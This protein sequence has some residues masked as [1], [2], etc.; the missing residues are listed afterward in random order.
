MHW[1]SFC[2]RLLVGEVPL[3]ENQQFQSPWNIS[4]AS[5]LR[6][7]QMFPTVPQS[8]ENVV[9]IKGNGEEPLD[10]YSSCEEML[11]DLQTS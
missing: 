11:E 5:F 7:S 1:V 2:M 3:K 6:I 9:V 4:G 8:L 10:R